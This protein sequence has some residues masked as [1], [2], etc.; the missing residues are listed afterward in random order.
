MACPTGCGYIPSQWATVCP[1]ATRKGGI[2]YIG[3]MSCELAPTDDEIADPDYWCGLMA[4]VDIPVAL[5]PKLIGVK[6]APTFTDSIKDSCT[7]A[8]IDGITQMVTFES[9]EM[10]NTDTGAR[11]DQFLDVLWWNAVMANAKRLLFFYI[12]CE[13]R[14]WGLYSNVSVRVGYE[15]PNQS[16]TL[17]KWAG[18]ISWFGDQTQPFVIPGIVSILQGTGCP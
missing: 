9:F 12:D 6:P 15:Q 17:S 14:L 4:E 2:P 18:Q 5:S 13:D 1:T 3:V 11:T 7:P 16:I 8:T 10:N